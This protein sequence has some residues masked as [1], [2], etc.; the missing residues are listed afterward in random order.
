MLNQYP[1]TRHFTY[2]LAASKSSSN[3]YIPFSSYVNR[4]LGSKHVANMK[5]K[6]SW[7]LEIKAEIG[8]R[9]S[10]VL[11]ASRGF[12]IFIFYFFALTS[13]HLIFR[14]YKKKIITIQKKK[15]I[16]Y[17]IFVLSNIRFGINHSHKYSLWLLCN[18]TKVKTL[19][20]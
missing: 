4:N 13:F 15:K 11:D 10:G 17:S 6:Y 16:L 18:K 20:W 8:K 19:L 2:L 7:R 12:F 9:F 3:V 5:M 1:I 14:K